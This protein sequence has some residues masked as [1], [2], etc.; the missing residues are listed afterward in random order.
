MHE[1][2]END[3][4]LFGQHPAELLVMSVALLLVDGS[5]GLEQ[6]RVVLR[7]VP[8]GLRPFRVLG[9]GNAQALACRAHRPC[10][11]HNRPLEPDV[12]PEAVG[13]GHDDVDVESGGLGHFSEDLGHAN[14]ARHAFG[15]IKVKFQAVR[16]TGLG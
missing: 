5:V 10:R 14:H 11:G 9:V 2:G 1:H 7:A 12:V 8:V 15:G 4:A 6:E 16:M 3:A 13:R